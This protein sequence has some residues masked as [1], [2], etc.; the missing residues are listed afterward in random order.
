MSRHTRTLGASFSVVAMIATADHAGLSRR[1]P[2]FPRSSVA[3]D[4]LAVM[5]DVGG[6]SVIQRRALAGETVA[7]E[8]YLLGGARQVDASTAGIEAVLLS[9]SEYGT[10]SFPGAATREAE[11]RTGSGVGVGVEPDWTTIGFVGLA[12]DFDSTWAIVADR[13]MHPTLDSTAVAIGKR[14]VLAAIAAR[15]AGPDGIVRQMAESV[16]YAGHPYQNPTG[17]TV[18]SVSALTPAA[19]RDYQANQVVGSRLLVVVAG[20]LTRARVEGAVQRTLATLPKGAYKWTLPEPWKP[21]A[22]TIAVKRQQL[23]TNYIFGLFGG[24]QASSAEVNALES[25]LGNIGG[26]A[27]ALMRDSG[28]TYDAGAGMLS[29]GATGG[30]L[31]VSTGSP[32]RALKIFNDWI[33]AY[34]TANFRQVN[35]TASNYA[36]EY[37]SMME[38]P[39]SQVNILAESYLYHGDFRYRENFASTVRQMSPTDMQR[40]LRAY[41]KNVQW[42]Y[43]GDTMQLPRALM[44]KY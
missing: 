27:N 16:A 44:T 21:T 24:P 6:I 32:A 37:L 12:E 40:A 33:D 20:N 36:S 4:S 31:H 9:A 13:L 29:Q 2:A 7:A 15:T 5:Y 1:V 26:A 3:A 19:V 14:H 38:T 11:S 23:P 42:A 34:M 41:L 18:A 25:G 10:K 35:G 17:G 39:R 8:I 22:T 30:V 43:L 28:L